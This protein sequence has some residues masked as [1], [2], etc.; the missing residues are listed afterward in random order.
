MRLKARAWLIGISVVVLVAPLWVTQAAEDEGFVK[1]KGGGDTTGDSTF[2]NPQKTGEKKGSSASSPVAKATGNAMEK[3]SYTRVKN[4]VRVVI[5]GQGLDKAFGQRLKNP[6]RYLLVFPDVRQAFS[7]NKFNVNMGPVVAIRVAE[8]VKRGRKEVHLVVD[9][10]QGPVSINKV[11]AADEFVLE[12]KAKPQGVS[13]RPLSGEAVS[14]VKQVYRLVEI[15]AKSL[16]EELR[17]VITA[18]GQ[19]R[20]KVSKEDDPRRLNVDFY[21]ALLDAPKSE[22]SF[23]EEGVTR[24]LARHVQRRPI[25]VSRISL[26]LR[27]AVKYSVRRDHNQLVIS[28]EKPAPQRPRESARG[29]LNH[30]VSLDLQRADMMGVLKT[31]GTEAGFDVLIDEEVVGTVTQVLRDVPL[32]E[33][34]SKILASTNYT[35][36]IQNNVLWVGTATKMM[37][38][39]GNMIQQIQTIAVAGYNLDEVVSKIRPFLAPTNVANIVTDAV[40][41]RLII[42]GVREDIDEIRAMLKR[43]EYI[44]ES[45][46]TESQMITRFYRLNYISPDEGLLLIGPHLANA[47]V[48]IIQTDARNNSLIVTC[49]SSFMPKIEELL[50]NV[51]LPVPQVMIEAKLVDVNLENIREVGVSWVG[52]AAGSA[53]GTNVSGSGVVDVFPAG[54]AMGDL[55][56]GVL[57]QNM[58]LTFTL[59]ALENNNQAEVISAPRIAVQSTSV[60]KALAHV[61]GAQINTMRSFIYVQTTRDIDATTGLITTTYEYITKELPINLSVVP[62][63]NEKGEVTMGIIASVESV[64]GAV[65]AEGPPPTTTQSTKTVI[66]VQD[67]ET[68]VIGG[69]IREEEIKGERRIPMLCH[70][71]ILG[72]LLFTSSYTKITKWELLIFITPRV[73]SVSG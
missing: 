24:L 49:H 33:A 57:R 10:E 65:P 45:E 27:P 17:V 55:T 66:T 2:V 44:G 58:D 52:N 59:S 34:L 12:L 11:Q 60:D 73:M 21:G 32:W 9:L 68:V 70:I 5:K 56:I 37:T 28:V 48:T 47:G 35:Y 46:K 3:V 53:G 6:S 39:K 38:A 72:R 18:D 63:V 42:K 20:Y 15:D 54:G 43:F 14:T 36:E 30:K 23:Q 19:I 71:P 69:L 13:Q 62:S 67:G 26:D 22:L 29:N 7:Q 31:L 41:S 50:A 61:G 51:D 25:N 40:K 8:H 1:P 16:P 4:G 64:W